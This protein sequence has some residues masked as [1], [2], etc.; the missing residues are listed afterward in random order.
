MKTKKIQNLLKNLQKVLSNNNLAY[1]KKYT[2]LKCKNLFNLFII[3][4]ALLNFT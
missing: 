2:K 4:K 1:L 3:L